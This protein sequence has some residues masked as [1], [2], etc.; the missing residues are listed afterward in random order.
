MQRSA[1]SITSNIAEGFGRQG[2]KESRNLYTIARG[3][4]ADL[5]NQLLV[6]RD[7]GRINAGV[8]DE[9]SNLSLE[10]RRLLAGL[11]RSIS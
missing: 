3:S 7:T 10:V 6:A 8:F 4:L 1:L 2:Q 9:L 11:I 5:Q